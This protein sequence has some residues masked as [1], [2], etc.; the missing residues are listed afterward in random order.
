M[1][2]LLLSMLFV[3]LVAALVLMV[4]RGA[5]SQQAAR[6]F[7]LIASVL[8][9][10]LSLAFA[11][12]YLQLPAKDGPRMSPVEPRYSVAYHWFTYGGTAENNAAHTPLQ[13]DFLFGFDGIS[14]SLVLLTTLLTVSGVL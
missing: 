10:F 8:T 1:N 2:A 13:F 14:L 12:E 11:N 4:G 3:P 9:L 6:R 7:A 5:F